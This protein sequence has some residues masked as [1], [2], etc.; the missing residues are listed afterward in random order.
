[1]SAADAPDIRAGS[2][3]V[4]RTA[5]HG[6]ESANGD[7]EQYHAIVP[8]LTSR[9]T[10]AITR[11]ITGQDTMDQSENPETLRANAF[12]GRYLGENVV[13]AETL[14]SMSEIIREFRRRTPR[15]IVTKCIDGR[16]HGSKGKGY[17]QTCIS[18]SRT[19]G[20]NV[21]LNLSN[22][23]FWNR[24][25]RVVED[26]K[27]HTPGM[28]ALFIALGH[29]SGHGHGCAAH[30]LNDEKALDA[31]R[32][33]AEA[34]REIYRKESDLLFVIHGMTNTDDMSERLV[35]PDGS[36][37]DTEKIIATMEK[38]TPFH[39]PADVFQ[40]DFLDRRLDDDAADRN[41][42]GLAPRAMLEGSDAPMYRDFQT[43]LAMES[44][45]VRETAKIQKGKGK[46]NDCIQPRV[47]EAV[48]HVLDS[49][50]GLPET[51]KGP[52]LY[53]TVWNIAYTLY[54]RRRIEGMSHEQ[55]E[56]KLDHAEE[57]VCYGEGFETLPRNKCVLVKTGRGNDEEALHVARKVLLNN[58][59]RYNK[60][61][62]PQEHPP[63]V[64]INVEVSGE[65]TNWDAF[66]DH[67][68]SR[69]RTMLRPIHRVFSKDVRVLTTYS[70]K[71]Q[72]RFYPVRIDSKEFLS[73]T[74]E[75]GQQQSYRID[76]TRSLVDQNFTEIELERREN[77]YTQH[78]LQEQSA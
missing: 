20:N 76:V 78:M 39:H 5:D 55:K 13:A 75:A 15:M 32:V 47:Y 2:T 66:N 50:Q 30:G 45:L 70:Y 19:E 11:L 22:T 67:V 35:F 34:V 72:K 33:Q 3:E 61:S 42:G 26:A 21:D 51:L 57:L 65:L 59:E 56:L 24:I 23:Q 41:V 6:R 1:M 58:R 71:D 73:E 49:I 40:P 62:K 10:M 36:E 54:Q 16:V 4:I 77:A 46:R 37:L 25:D 53:Q 38:E 17:P 8:A 60:Q 28:P 31:V 68:L 18:F 44:Y 27:R 69:L 43:A 64:H 74:G 14:S 52:L 9:N 29:R 48:M 63:L 7:M 12:F